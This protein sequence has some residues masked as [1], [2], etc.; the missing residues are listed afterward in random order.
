[1]KRLR[2]VWSDP[3]AFVRRPVRFA[4]RAGLVTGLALTI[5]FYIFL[6]LRIPILGNFLF[7]VPG[8][9]GMVLNLHDFLSFLVIVYWMYLIRHLRL[10][11]SPLVPF[12][13]FFLHAVLEPYLLLGLQGAA[14]IRANRPFTFYLSYPLALCALA[15]WLMVWRCQ[16]REV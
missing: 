9:V 8:Q 4:V 14:F 6:V 5:C 16:A 10:T 7:L 3:G 13:V 12:G 11:D 1:M 15:A 2:L